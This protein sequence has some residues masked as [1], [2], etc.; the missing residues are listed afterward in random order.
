MHLTL[1]TPH[2]PFPIDHPRKLL[3]Q[4]KEPI[5][6]LL[7]LAIRPSMSSYPR[8]LPPQEFRVNYTVS[9]PQGRRVSVMRGEYVA[10]NGTEDGVPKIRGYRW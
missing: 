4:R 9:P 5:L 8:Q 7:H 6:S 10:R 3:P 1:L 2:N